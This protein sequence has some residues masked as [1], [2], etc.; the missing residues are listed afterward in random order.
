MRIDMRDLGNAEVLAGAINGRKVLSK[1]L[2]QTDKER[3]AP[4]AVF[5]DFRHINVATASFL[6]ETVLAYRDSIRGRR[7]N[8]YP[9]VANPNQVVEE[10]LKILVSS[11]A[12]TLMLCTLDENDRPHQPRLLGRLDPKQRLT[13][14]FVQ[15]C[16]ETDA[17]ELKRA[18]AKSEK[19][20]QNAW[21]NRLSALANLGLIVEL[22]EGRA[23][24]YRP[25]L[26]GASYGN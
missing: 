15:Q 9:V 24:R 20:K 3:V 5:L 19:V 6:R 22:S 12:D 7:S 17:A 4:E 26:V 25:L 18:H 11:N 1:L 13:F 23:K 21:N 14:D 10:E 8:F 16:Q 2:E